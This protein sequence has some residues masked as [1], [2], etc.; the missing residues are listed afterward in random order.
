MPFKDN[1]DF[2]PPRNR[3]IK[4]WRYMSFAKFASLL[5]REELF[6]S[7]FA[8]LDD[9]SEGYFDKTVI[10]FL[11]GLIKDDKLFDK[12]IRTLWESTKQ[13]M[14][15]NRK[16]NCVCAWHRNASESASMWKAYSNYTDGIAIQS[17][18]NRLLE[19]Y[20]DEKK[21]I[22]IGVVN[23]S[24]INSQTLNIKV[25][26]NYFKNHFL[27]K[28]VIYKDEKELRA[29]TKSNKDLTNPGKLPGLYIR[30]NLDTLIEK[31]YLAP[32]SPEWIKELI[33]ALLKRFDLNKDVKFS[34]V[35]TPPDYI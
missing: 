21:D 27:N 11:D 35:D 15:E 4:I 24:N 22:N 32:G 12:K 7:V 10:D 14:K 1:P 28:R 2:K 3:N 13:K 29:I 16:F 31:I 8:K 19:S 34:I 23:Y 25:L 9:K 33:D 26:E 20:R 5:Q 17:T 6:F 30:T 18:Y